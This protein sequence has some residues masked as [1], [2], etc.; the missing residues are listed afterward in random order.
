MMTSLW[1]SLQGV[2]DVTSTSMKSPDYVLSEIERVLSD[3]SIEY[4][5][6][7]LASLV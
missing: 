3:M 2:Y 1:L 5:R 7:K 6:K 4:K